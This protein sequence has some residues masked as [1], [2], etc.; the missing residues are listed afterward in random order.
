MAR[1]RKAQTLGG[2]NEKHSGCKKAKL[3]LTK[4][5]V[6]HSV[7][8]QYYDTVQ[9]LREYLLSKLPGSSR[10]RRKKIASLGKDEIQPSKEGHDLILELSLLLDT[11]LVC[12]HHRPQAQ[13]DSR[14]EQWRSF[15]QKADESI[16]S[17]SGDLASATCSQSE[18]P[19]CNPNSF[20]SQAD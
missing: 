6:K 17:A 14:W 18:V 2:P 3:D 20:V 8:Q 7:L 5:Q 12:T 16:V 11:T 13:T 9:T 10:L 15:S 4:S 19:P 1:K